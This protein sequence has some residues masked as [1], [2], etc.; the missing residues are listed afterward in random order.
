MN[1]TLVRWW[2]PLLILLASFVVPRAHAQQGFAPATVGKSY[3]L[4][5]LLKVGGKPLVGKW[6]L[7]EDGLSQTR[8]F[9]RTDAK[10]QL[11]FSSSV[12][13][14]G[15]RQAIVRF[16][17]N[18]R[19]LG[20]L[21]IPVKAEVIR[22]HSLRL[23]NR[24]N[25]AL[26]A[27]IRAADGTF[28][29][30]KLNPGESKLVLREPSQGFRWTW[31][32]NFWTGREIAVPFGGGQMMVSNTGEAEV[33]VFAGVGLLRAAVVRSSGSTGLCW[34][35]ELGV[36]GAASLGG[37]LCLATDGASLGADAVAGGTVIAVSVRFA[38]W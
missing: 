14:P 21:A 22:V 4:A 38:A 26:R 2:I 33:N 24:S 32:P 3:P 7:I 35:P 34:A 37:A 18:G 13:G 29:S 27:E 17:D 12:V 20:R 25:R 16:K 9:L 36:S 30:V 28:T 15:G 5:V 6:V 8:R 23:K 19:E 31:L 11:R 1:I 10:G